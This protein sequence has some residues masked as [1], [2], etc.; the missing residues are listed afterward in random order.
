[1]HAV[2]YEPVAHRLR[3][4][5]AGFWSVDDVQR[6]GAALLAAV[7]PIPEGSRDF[8]V[9]IDATDFPVQT[10]EVSTA[11]NRIMTVADQMN[12][13]GRKVIVVGSV[14]NK[15]QAQRALASPTVRVFL[16][17][18]EAEAWLASPRAERA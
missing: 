12:P 16:A 10:Q 2:R 9:L 3:I 7:G 4:R 1:M 13:T 6:Y 11:L 8:D 17:M 15:L 18:G 14:M 5:I